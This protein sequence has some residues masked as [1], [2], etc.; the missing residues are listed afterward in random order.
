MKRDFPAIVSTYVVCAIV[1]LVLG[2]HWRYF[3]FWPWYLS[4]IIVNALGG[5]P[6]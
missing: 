2:G 4:K 6:W 3:L 1:A 5:I